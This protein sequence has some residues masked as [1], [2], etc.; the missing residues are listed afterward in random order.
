VAE[1]PDTNLPV[2]PTRAL[3]R[4][5]FRVRRRER[6][7]KADELPAFYA[8]V[9]ALD[10]PVAADYLTLLL[11]SGLRR[12][13]AASLTWNDVDLAGRVLRIP[14]ARNKG[15]RRFDLPLTDFLRDLFVARRSLGRTEY[16]F[17]SIGASGYIA[18]PKFPLNQ[19]ALATGIKVSAHDLRR[20]YETVAESTDI[21]PLALK[22]LINHS[23]P[24]DAMTGYVIMSR[25]RLLEAA[26]R[27]TDKMKM[28]C[29]IDDTTGE[30]V[31][32]L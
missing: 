17:P 31:V 25:E 20:T 18:E 9:R 19:V 29:K 32:K 1:K 30:N 16:I 21:S 7:V 22:A 26:Q 10:N 23:L 12:E 15:D 13:E 11:F 5:W 27:V 2:N 6:L 28:L 8:A 4:H 14:A 24:K 3:R